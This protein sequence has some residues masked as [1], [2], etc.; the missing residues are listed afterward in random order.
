M[1]HFHRNILTGEIVPNL[2]KI[3]FVNYKNVDHFLNYLKDKKIN[4]YSVTKG[5]PFKNETTGKW[6]IQLK[7]VQHFRSNG[8][9]IEQTKIDGVVELNDI[10][11]NVSKR[12]Q[13]WPTFI[14]TGEPRIFYNHEKGVHEIK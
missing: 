8:R 4:C 12:W 7:I 11:K 6:L 2:K 13:Q 5:V 14:N 9:K 3:K 10:T 1:A